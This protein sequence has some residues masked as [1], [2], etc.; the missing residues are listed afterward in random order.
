MKYGWALWLALI[1]IWING[2]SFG[3]MARGH[4]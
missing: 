4:F 2:V 3:W 1:F